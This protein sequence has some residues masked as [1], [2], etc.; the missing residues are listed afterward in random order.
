[1]NIHDVDDDD[2]GFDGGNGEAKGFQDLM[3]DFKYITSLSKL[4]DTLRDAI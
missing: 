4:I 2:D 1:M 3:V